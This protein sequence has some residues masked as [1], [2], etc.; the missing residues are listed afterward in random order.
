[1]LL[2]LLK[3]W[4]LC[5]WLTALSGL[6]PPRSATGDTNYLADAEQWLS[7]YEYSSESVYQQ[8]LLHDWNNNYYGTAVLLASLTDQALLRTQQARK[9]WVSC[10]GSRQTVPSECCVEAF[11]R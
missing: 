4:W 10:N 7:G 5:G 9:S 11:L 2:E 3:A 8:Q 6:A 1:V